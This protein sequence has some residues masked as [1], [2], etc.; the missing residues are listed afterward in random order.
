MIGLTLGRYLS[1]R[2]LETILTIF[3]AISGLSF[4]IDFVEL[5]RR[6][7][8]VPN[9]HTGFVAIMSFL[10]VPSVS[11]QILPFAV[12]FGTMAAFVNLSRKLEL[13]VARASGVSVWGF[14]VPP[15]L[16]AVVVGIVSVVVY[17]PMAAS[18]K[19]RA[20]R[21]EIEAFGRPGNEKDASFW[22]RQRSVDGK[23]TIRADRM[24]DG[25]STLLNV[26]AYLDDRRDTFVER[27]E[28]P[29]AT[30][31][32]RAW[33]FDNATVVR[34]GEPAQTI[35]TYYLATDLTAQD[36]VQSVTSPDSVPFWDLPT[37]EERTE[38]AGLDGTQYRLQ[39]QSLLARPL[40][41]VAMVLVAAAFSLR[42]FRFGGVGKMVASGIAAGFV[43]YVAT[44]MVA[45]LGGAGLLSA[46][47]AA[48]SPALVGSLLGAL[49]LLHQE[50]G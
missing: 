23:A 41:L 15:L 24:T 17:N 20:D 49:A 22:L 19:Q 1:W 37:F 5:L 47:I 48:W 25:G 12:L 50:D 31:T 35:G 28:A 4:L 44:K 18:M 39:Y 43:L 16:I 9:V 45:N 40:L 7:G 11:E 2:F 32:A 30:L 3:V 13:V 8:D 21:M 38:T 14:L 27:I 42:F 29:R 34:P 46:P 26:V 36:V 33:R 10:R 6:A